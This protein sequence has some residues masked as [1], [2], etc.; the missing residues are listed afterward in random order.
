[1]GSKMKKLLVAVAVAGLTGTANAQSAFEG[2]YAQAGIGYEMVSPS[3]SFGNLNITNNGSPVASVPTSA[4][5]NS[6]NSFAGTITAGYN[7]VITKDFLLGIG[8][9]YSPL[10]GSNANYSATYSSYGT[11]NGKYNKENSYNIFISPATPVGKDGLLYGKVGYTGASVKSQCD[12]CS[13]TTTNLTGYSLGLG[14]KQIISGGLYGFGE[15]NYASYG[16]KSSSD[17]ATF[18]TY[19]ASQTSTVSANV[20]NFLIGV[21]YRF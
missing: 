8:A 16:N 2:F 9:E 1:M 10:A 5:I 11:A 7:F 3:L 6:S 20:T 14:Y 17:T 19:R 21:G 15:V 4:T 13:S 18:S 12:G